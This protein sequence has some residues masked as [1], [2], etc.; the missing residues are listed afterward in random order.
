[1]NPS[2]S[3]KSLQVAFVTR[4]PD[5]ECA[6][7][8]AISDTRLLSPASIVRRR[9]RQARVLHAAEGKARRHDED[10]VAVPAVRAVELLAGLQHPRH[11]RELAPPRRRRD[12]SARRRARSPTAELEVADRDSHQVRRESA[13]SSR[14]GRRRCRALGRPRGAHHRDEFRRR[15]DAGAVRHADAAGVSWIGIQLRAWIACALA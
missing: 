1:M 8:C 5:H 11:V 6:S 7:S 3:Q 12:G 13:A 10:V 15:A 9:E 4:L 14:S 2:L